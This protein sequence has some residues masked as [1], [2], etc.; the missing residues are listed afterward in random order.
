[1]TKNYP[2]VS[3]IFPNWNG[4][5]DTLDCLNSLRNLQ[6][7]KNN[8]E[9]I[10]SDNGSSDGSQSA[11]KTHFAIMKNEGWAA[12]KL[13]ENM[14]NLGPAIAR[15][16][17]IKAAN[18]KFSYIWLIDN[19]IIVDPKALIELLK[20]AENYE[21][22]KIIG[23]INYLFDNPEEISFCGS[24]ID[25]RILKFK[26][27]DKKIL[28]KYISLIVDEVAGSSLLV[29]R[30]TLQKIGIFDPDY[31]CYYNDTDLCI[32]VRK[33]GYKISITLNSKIWHKVSNSTRYVSGFSNYFYTRNII[34]LIKKHVK[35]LK[36]IYFLFGFFLYF[37]PKRVL[38]TIVNRNIHDLKQIFYGLR[39]GL[40][41]NPQSFFN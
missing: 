11:I 40:F 26:H 5:R 27:I 19:D 14:T 4:K 34:L 1:M 30:K 28:Q 16:I 17:G 31:F 7:E 32:R 24:V 22:I 6:Y 18:N 12:L 23:S 8:L 37:L 38:K 25:W 29:K 39:D 15:N 2:L 21:E 33:A 20:I 13:I 35:L 41:S 36:Y 9:I 3:I 10:I